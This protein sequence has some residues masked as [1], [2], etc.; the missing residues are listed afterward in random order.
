MDEA[1]TASGHSSW[2][3][4]T[5]YVPLTGADRATFAWEFA[6]RK[7]GS[8]ACTPSSGTALTDNILLVREEE[9][10]TLPGLR[11]ALPPAS[12]GELSAVQWDWTCDPSVLP[13]TALPA[14][15]GFDLRDLCLPAVVMRGRTAEH[16]LIADGPV[17]LRLAVLDGTLLDG[18]V[19][20]HYHLPQGHEPANLRVLRRL[21]TLRRCGHLSGTRSLSAAR[22]SR[23]AAVLRAWD[24]HC[25]GAS[26]R[27]IACLL[28]GRSRVREDWNGR[29]DYLRMRVYRMIHSAR[30]L[31]N[32]DWWTL[33]R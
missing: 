2:A 5:A 30:R 1:R 14:R 10:S 11:F 33:L 17:R 24:A 32:G 16:V 15:K 7:C 6:R 28:W 12:P 19:R 4:D 20:F 9:P 3:D 26:Q 8:P 31:V 13:V 18:A 23:W 25:A 27:D 29:S 22:A 21:M